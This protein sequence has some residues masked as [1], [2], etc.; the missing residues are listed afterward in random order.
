MASMNVGVGE[1]S[2]GR[3][4]D[5]LTSSGI[6]SCVVVSVYD[7][8]QRTGAMAHA[9]LPSASAWADPSD[10]KYVDAAI[11][12]MIAKVIAHGAGRG[13]LVAK[14]VGGANMFVD[15]GSGIGT[16]NVTA[17]K[18][19][20]KAEGIELVGQCVGGVLG[21]SVEFCTASGAMRV[22]VSF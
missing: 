21:R 3:G 1:V 8:K 17:A 16:Q 12:A 6:G 11:D 14:I 10:T 20:L 7:R 19:K 18:E 22:T 2:V 15:F 13:H 4:S 9:L 5:I